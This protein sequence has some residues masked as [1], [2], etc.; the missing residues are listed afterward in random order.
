MKD[1]DSTQKSTGAVNKGS[2]NPVHLDVLV[3]PDEDARKRDPLNC[4]YG[5][6]QCLLD[7]P[8]LSGAFKAAARHA[9]QLVSMGKC[10]RLA[11]TV[12]FGANVTL[13]PPPSGS[14]GCAFA[15]VYSSAVVPQASI[16]TWQTIV[17]QGALHCRPVR[18]WSACVDRLV[19][20]A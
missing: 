5:E 14:E 15:F 13:F 10:R 17:V 8:T 4:T 1:S 7:V 19:D 12:Q 18:K 11:Y 2:E 20:Q 9:Q 16:S 3:W 6:T